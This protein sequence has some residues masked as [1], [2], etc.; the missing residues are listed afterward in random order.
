MASMLYP[1]IPLQSSLRIRGAE[2]PPRCR[3]GH[4]RPFASPPVGGDTGDSAHPAAP[5]R[6]GLKTGVRLL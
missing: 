1:S 4:R 2:Q 6:A 3:G 5:R